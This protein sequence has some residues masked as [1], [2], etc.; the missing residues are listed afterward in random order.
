MNWQTGAVLQRTR[1][2][3]TCIPNRAALF[4]NYATFLPLD[5]IYNSR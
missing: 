5:C 1:L 4:E 3:A 2:N